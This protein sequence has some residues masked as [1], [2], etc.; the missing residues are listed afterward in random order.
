MT[1]DFTVPPHA[2]FTSTNDYI[3]GIH[4]IFYQHWEVLDKER[5][6][7]IEKINKWRSDQ[8]KQITKYAEEQTARL[9][10]N[11]NRL[12][13]V[14]DEK[15]KENLETANAYYDAH[16]LDLFNELR[17][18]CQSLKFQV[19][20]L[21]FYKYELE[22]PKVINLEEQV[23]KK[24]S[25]QINTN[26]RDEARRRRRLQK[27]ISSN[28]GNSSGTTTSPPPNMV[29]TNSKQTKCVCLL[30]HFLVVAL[31]ISFIA[32]SNYQIQNKKRRMISQQPIMMMSRLINV[33]YVL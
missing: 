12:R 21:E 11:Y 24:N 10:E 4:N 6:A 16:Q 5:Q 32:I 27:D 8:K 28:T 17:D 26:T 3:D 22:Y 31:S 2:W 15:H 20:T 23:E 30:K 9:N 18:V 33:R 13:L 19:S 14:F 29:T 25:E 7:L 1:N